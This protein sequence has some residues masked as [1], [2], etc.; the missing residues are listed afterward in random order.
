[1]EIK[2]KSEEKYS[3]ITPVTEKL[4]SMVSPMLKAEAVLLNGKGI[5]NLII[6]LGEVKY[7]DSSG[8]SSILVANR[9]CNAS[10]GVL[11]LCHIQENPLKLISISQLDSILNIVPSEEEAIEYVYMDDIEKSLEE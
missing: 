3:I 6:N 10:G 5:K 2:V 1:M 4:D 9:L 11:V 8:L 7:I